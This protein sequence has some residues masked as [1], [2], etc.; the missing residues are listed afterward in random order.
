MLATFCHTN[1]DW[2]AF[3][4]DAVFTMTS[5]NWRSPDTSV[6]KRSR[7]LAVEILPVRA[8]FAPDVAFEILSPS[9]SASEVQS[10]RQDY[11]DSGVIQAWIDPEKRSL[12]LI[13]PDRPLQFFQGQQPLGISR[14]PGFQLIPEDLFKI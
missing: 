5:G 12:E 9:W 8:E 14:L 11:L 1:P 13:E 7:F 3:G 10:K 6:V 2:M 4:S